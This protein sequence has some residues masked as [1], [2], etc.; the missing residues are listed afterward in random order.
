ML[1]T[2]LITWLLC[3]ATSHITSVWLATP[4]N[5]TEQSGSN[6]HNAVRPASN[7]QTKTI[8]YWQPAPAPTFASLT[9]AGSSH[10]LSAASSSLKPAIV[11]SGDPIV[12]QQLP[13]RRSET[14]AQDPFRVLDIDNNNPADDSSGGSRHQRPDQNDNHHSQVVN[15]SNAQVQFDEEQQ[16]FQQQLNNNNNRNSDSAYG[17][18][19]NGTVSND[20]D[21]N[22]DNQSTR[23]N[24][25]N[26]TN[27]NHNYYGFSKNLT[28]ANYDNGNQP[29]NSSHH[30]YGVLSNNNNSHYVVSNS[31][32]LDPMDDGAYDVTNE[33]A[34]GSLSPS[35]QSGEGDQNDLKRKLPAD[36]NN[37]KVNINFNQNIRPI[38]SS[39]W[40][41]TQQQHNSFARPSN[42]SSLLYFLSEPS[43]QPIN[44][45]EPASSQPTTASTPAATTALDIQRV[46]FSS[47]D[48]WRRP[49]VHR[50]MHH[51]A[52]NEMDRQTSPTT[53]LATTVA[54][55]THSTADAFSTATTASLES[56]PPAPARLDTNRTILLLNSRP[57]QILAPGDNQ[58]RWHQQQRPQYTVASQSDYRARAPVHHQ[59]NPAGPISVAHPLAYQLQM[60]RAIRRQK[61]ANSVG[62]SS[63]NKWPLSATDQ[64]F[65]RRPVTSV[66]R[67]SDILIEHRRRRQQN[68][69]EQMQAIHAINKPNSQRRG[70]KPA[71][72]VERVKSVPQSNKLLMS[73]GNRKLSLFGSLGNRFN[74]WGG[75]PNDYSSQDQSQIQATLESAFFDGLPSSS[76]QWIRPP[77]ASGH[78]NRRR[79]PSNGMSGSTNSYRA[80]G[81]S[82]RPSY[83]NPYAYAMINSAGASNFYGDN[84]DRH[85]AS[86]GVGSSSSAGSS[87]LSP[88]PQVTFYAPAATISHPQV[89]Q[90][91]QNSLDRIYGI[92]YATA[93]Q[94]QLPTITFAPNTGAWAQAPLSPTSLLVQPVP[95]TPQQVRRRR[96]PMSAPSAATMAVVVDGN[97]PQ[98]GA[99]SQLVPHAARAAPS[100]TGRPGFIPVVALQVTRTS[101]APTSLR[102]SS[103]DQAIELQ[104]V[105]GN[106]EADRTRNELDA[107]LEAKTGTGS[108]SATSNRGGEYNSLASSVSM[109]GP[110]ASSNT[111]SNN[112]IGTGA[113]PSTRSTE[114][115]TTIKSALFGYLPQQLAADAPNI[116]QALTVLS[117]LSQSGPPTLAQSSSSHQHI[118]SSPSDF[119]HHLAGLS[120]LDTSST[121]NSDHLNQPSLALQLQANNYAQNDIVHPFG[122]S[123]LLMPP[124]AD[125]TNQ[126]S[127]SAAQHL[128]FYPPAASQQHPYQASP[129]HPVQDPLKFS[130][131]GWL[132]GQAAAAAAVAGDQ[133]ANLL[134]AAGSELSPFIPAMVFANTPLQLDTGSSNDDTVATSTAPSSSS[135]SSNNN[136][137]DNEEQSTEQSVL[138]NLINSATGGGGSG[139]SSSKGVTNKKRS[140][141]FFASAGQLLL[142][143][144]PLLLVPSLGFMFSGANTNAN[145]ARYHAPNPLGPDPVHPVLQAVAAGS[146]NKGSFQ[147]TGYLSDG[148][149]MNAQP[150]PQMFTPIPPTA[151]SENNYSDSPQVYQ[152]QGQRNVSTDAQINN[153]TQQVATANLFVSGPV[154]AALSTT[155][156]KRPMVTTNP[157]MRMAASSIVGSISPHYGSNYN[158]PSNKHPYKPQTSTTV[159]PNLSAARS[160]AST[161][162]S[163]PVFH[164][165][166]D[167]QPINYSQPNIISTETSRRPISTVIITTMPPTNSNNYTISDTPI[168]ITDDD[169]FT[170]FNG[171]NSTTG[172]DGSITIKQPTILLVTH[173]DDMGNVTDYN[174]IMQRR[175]DLHQAN[176]TQKNSTI[177]NLKPNQQVMA[178][179]GI[180]NY[181]KG[182][183]VDK[184]HQHKNYEYG[185]EGADFDAQFASLP[186]IRNNHSN[187][188]SRIGGSIK[189]SSSMVNKPQPSYLTTPL[190][191]LKHIRDKNRYQYTEVSNGTSDYSVSLDQS[192][193]Y[194]AHLI[195]QQQQ[196]PTRWPQRVDIFT[197]SPLPQTSSRPAKLNESLVA[198][199]SNS[200]D[201]STRLYPLSTWPPMRRRTVSLITANGNKTVPDASS[202]YT[203]SYIATGMDNSSRSDDGM[204]IID[205]LVSEIV[206]PSR[207][208]SAARR[209]S[210]RSVVERQGSNQSAKASRKSNRRRYLARRVIRMRPRGEPEKTST[211]VGQLDGAETQAKVAINEMI[212]PAKNNDRIII[213][214]N[215]VKGPILSDR[216]DGD[217]YYDSE[218][219]LQ[220]NNID[221][222]REDD[223]RSKS[224][225]LITAMIEHLDDT[226]PDSNSVNGPMPGSGTIRNASDWDMRE[227]I[228]RKKMVL[229]R[230]ATHSYALPSEEVTESNNNHRPVSD[231]LDLGLGGRGR[232]LGAD[233]NRSNGSAVMRLGNHRYAGDDQD[234][235]DTNER[236]NS[237]ELNDDTK[238]ALAKFG[239]LLLQDTLQV[240]GNHRSNLSSN[241]NLLDISKRHRHQVSARLIKLDHDNYPPTRSNEGGTVAATERYYSHS[242]TRAPE[243]MQTDAWLDSRYNISDDY[244]MNQRRRSY[245]SQVN[246]SDQWP[247]RAA[248]ERQQYSPPN[249][250]YSY[251]NYDQS[252]G[253]NSEYQSGANQDSPINRYNNFLASTVNADN[254]SSLHNYPF[255]NSSSPA[256]S[257]PSRSMTNRGSGGDNGSPD[258]PLIDS[259]YSLYNSSKSSSYPNIS[260]S[261]PAPGEPSRYEA[262]NR[263]PTSHYSTDPYRSTTANQYHPEDRTN[264][265]PYSQQDHYQT[266]LDTPLYSNRRPYPVE[267]TAPPHDPHQLH[268]HQHHNQYPQPLPPPS[269]HPHHRTAYGE[270]VPFEPSRDRVRPTYQPYL[271]PPHPA[272]EPSPHY[273]VGGQY[274][275]SV[276]VRRPIMRP[277]AESGG[278]LNPYAPSTGV[279]NPFAPSSRA[280]DGAVKDYLE[281]AQFSDSDR[282]KLMA[283]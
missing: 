231:Q 249:S 271:A 8:Q 142:S 63:T 51:A 216:M 199:S 183:I 194:R 47:N 37:N 99:S 154:G 213:N 244:P 50:I 274:A 219:A 2:I 29:T 215:R 143:A 25:H 96:R 53:T 148:Y 166:I 16:Q 226:N 3:D 46:K 132:A 268:H 161:N 254:A 69:G 85:P 172:S 64:Q 7:H 103:G 240:D 93:A 260:D 175:D 49:Q 190:P 32:S 217:N 246:A 94:Q 98:L 117:Q 106:N 125:Q 280:E 247:W 151:A 177:W 6:D 157:V 71:T 67:P 278:G 84:T 122:G 86:T 140:S 91:A 277:P 184:K 282:D 276:P 73:N 9:P 97:S 58:I 42:Q 267:G 269:Y 182:P 135:D 281:R 107:Y 56:P 38:Q 150:T 110:Q 205:D 211:T 128:F 129:V 80:T 145:A 12:Q 136:D 57:Q 139:S 266:N 21:S 20:Y 201:T 76:D 152:Y 265:R 15:V 90:A 192:P 130:T 138:Q 114:H 61:L 239:K 27:N 126:R 149:V 242:V 137:D 78:Y 235:H 198:A 164:T 220:L 159:R 224:S 101:P 181:S 200:G 227:Q 171:T 174:E 185:Y 160:G 146:N 108:S 232:F 55:T 134:A 17:G 273:A 203:T 95:A 30:Q 187:S 210:K 272:R 22:I 13:Q 18:G 283:R 74:S 251:N 155:T 82:H 79:R 228:L 102:Q 119:T 257:I 100:A 35:S 236:K 127:A 109:A 36:S 66:Y 19:Y 1:N 173:E 189:P 4:A 165:L 188:S 105:N 112:G 10:L 88:M 225:H 209:R 207:V 195:G 14:V 208:R 141:D 115:M 279:S 230:I 243:S 156:T 233:R 158:H 245:R 44:H 168:V 250:H 81:S 34:F 262:A 263:Q 204:S 270:D 167:E 176:A 255:S 54:D 5:L 33:A 275:A 120:H 264:Y 92:G 153:S 41:P 59:W 197:L 11:D 121:A 222:L 221:T 65:I 241:N 147:S 212:T 186:T 113:S 253:R 248:D 193:P 104:Q 163:S 202:K 238:R 223:S 261:W 256:S 133:Q 234:I 237:L 196:Q 77:M 40:L 206:D 62:Q 23:Y 39:S 52:A 118:A 26:S 68:P 48:Q 45:Y 111:N 43:P 83:V 178:V 169:Y 123:Q 60:D 72:F 229:D 124:V 258:G 218:G 70:L 116:Q 87:Q 191:I 252:A 170:R 28:Q 179:D 180:G 214:R 24:L 31:N 75:S 89:A 131:N 259:R 144:L 162:A